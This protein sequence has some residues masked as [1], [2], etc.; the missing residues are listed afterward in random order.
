[1]T[2]KG[3]QLDCIYMGQSCF[4]SSFDR[5]STICSCWLFQIK[6]YSSCIHQSVRSELRPDS[7][8]LGPGGGYSPPLSKIQT[9]WVQGVVIASLSL[10]ESP[11]GELCRWLRLPPKWLEYLRKLPLPTEPKKQQKLEKIDWNISRHFLRP[12]RVRIRR[13]VE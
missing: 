4:H 2:V 1:M 8:P 6:Q 7:D 3:H 11:N 9:P 12:Q 13:D 5:S 10:E